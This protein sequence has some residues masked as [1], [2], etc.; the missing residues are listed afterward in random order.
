MKKASVYF[1]RFIISTLI[2]FQCP[3]TTHPSEQPEQASD[4]I[5]LH[6]PATMPARYPTET[7]VQLNVLGRT[8]KQLRDALKRYR[9]CLVDKDC[10]EEDRETV[11][12]ATNIMI[13]LTLPYA[14]LGII[15]TGEQ[16][17]KSQK[18]DKIP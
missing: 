8:M 6:E 13:Q 1:I 15:T 3:G 9:A 12:E 14:L 2:V 11:V 18:Q 7:Q 5:R 10:D 4:A 17:A 16:I